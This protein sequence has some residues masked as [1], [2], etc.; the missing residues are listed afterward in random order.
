MAAAAAA[1]ATT[2]EL[3][4]VGVTRLPG[5]GVDADEEDVAVGDVRLLFNEFEFR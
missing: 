2:A 5:V 3:F 1:A 4:E